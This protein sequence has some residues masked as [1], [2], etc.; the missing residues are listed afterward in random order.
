MQHQITTVVYCYE[1]WYCCRSHSNTQFEFISTIIQPHVKLL[2]SV[3]VLECAREL[4]CVQSSAPVVFAAVWLVRIMS[5]EDI[6][7]SLSISNNQAEGD[8]VIVPGPGAVSWA[9]RRLSG[10]A[11]ILQDGAVS[12]DPAPGG[13]ATPPAREGNTHLPDDAGA[14]LLLNWINN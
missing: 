2:S 9:S 13:L 1:L 12:A 8:H 10:P 6:R 11:F 5:S 4:T 14:S 3:K 7:N